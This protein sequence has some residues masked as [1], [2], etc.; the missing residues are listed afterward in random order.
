MQ[1]NIIKNKYNSEYAPLATIQQGATIEF[2]G[3][4][5]IDLYLNLNNLRIIVLDNIIN[6]TTKTNIA[7]NQRL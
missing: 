5:T 3:N 2:I 4:K 1:Q 7:S 6:A